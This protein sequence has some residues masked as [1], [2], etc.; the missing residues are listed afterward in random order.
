MDSVTITPDIEQ[1]L[2]AAERALEKLGARPLDINRHN[3]EAL[4]QRVTYILNGTYCR[5]DYAE[6]DG[7]GF[8]IISAIEE[9]RYA[10][11]GLMEDI[12]AIAI[13]STEEELEAGIRGALCTGE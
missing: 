4:G 8:I 3:R 12:A 10:E 11:I 9:A 7:A 6:F 5:V 1:K 13:E 2:A